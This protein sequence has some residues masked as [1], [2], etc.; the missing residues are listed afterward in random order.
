MVK[1]VWDRKYDETGNKSAP[2]RITLPF[3][4][5]ETLNESSQQRQKSIELFLNRRGST[6]WRNRLI[7]G[8]KKYVLPSLLSEFANSVD[9][10]YIDPPFDTGADF[11]Y[12]VEVPDHQVGSTFFTKLPS[13]IEMKAY[14]DTWGK[15]ST[16]LDSY[17]HWFNETVYLLEKLLKPT[18]TI[19]VHLDW[20]V[21]H[22]AKI[23]LDEVFGPNNFLVDITWK[24]VAFR[25]DS[26]HFGQVSD[27][28][29]V[30]SKSEQFTYNKQIVPYDEQYIKSHY[31]SEDAGGRFTTHNLTAAGQGQ[32]RRF[33]DR[34][35][36]PP[37]GT[38][39]RFSQE[40]IDRL[41]AEGKI[42]F[43]SS[44]NP[45][46]KMYSHEMTGKV[47]DS[48]WTDISPVN[49]QAQ[50]DT[51]YDTQKPEAL[52]ERII[53]TSSNEGDLVLDCFV[54]SGTTAAVAEKLN[55]RWIACD[56]SRF[57]LNTTRKR[58][59]NVQGVKPFVIQNLGKYERQ[60]WQ[61]AEFGIDAA[62]RIQ[63]YIS[64]ILEL[65]GAQPL[66]GYLWLH[67]MKGKRFVHVG[68]VDSPISP[69]DVGQIVAE[70]KRSIGTGKEA[71]RTNGID[72][73][74]W[75]F[76]FELNELAKQQAA[77]ANVDIRFLR[78]PREVLD[79]KAVEQGDVHFF[80]LASLDVGI[81]IY[82]KKV[83]ITINDF[84]IPADDVP[85]DIQKEIKHWSQ[86]IDYWSIDW[87]NKND[88]FHNEWQEYRTR[89]KPT[90]Q[91][92]SSKTYSEHGEYRIVVKVVDILG[93]DTT[94]MLQVKV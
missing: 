88:T 65:Y 51:G 40:N 80:E 79:K 13:V 28:I 64:F 37:S 84:V 55:R 66:N 23:V 21:G 4:T 48:I 26:G 45:R 5:I 42:V 8:D 1:L 61:T 72:V 76:A 11:S 34:T 24:R 83:T 56:L 6:E 69:L 70:F 89:E 31:T 16:H 32:P 75:D 36:A 3:Q 73:L 67:G 2:I 58:L 50:E 19:Y 53:K 14:R 63:S 78:I 9:L 82:D 43:T 81:K 29:L 94:K 39:W 15:G 62:A 46:Y 41:L 22:Y 91:T 44:G 17:L 68:S 10:I 71:P 93:N 59:L 60:A 52:L 7:W 35:I 54:G 12:R 85:T 92:E 33:G 27:Q 57:A 20:H 30:Y 38:H 25:H 87:N 49:S 90:L 47:V 18:G 86:W 74:G 77:Q